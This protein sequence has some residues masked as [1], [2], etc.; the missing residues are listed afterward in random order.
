MAEGILKRGKRHLILKFDGHPGLIIQA[1][2]GCVAI[3]DQKTG[4]ET[5]ELA[6]EMKWR[7]KMCNREAKKIYLMAEADRKRLNDY[8]TELTRAVCSIADVFKECKEQ[9]D[10]T[11]PETIKM[12]RQSRKRSALM[13]G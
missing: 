3:T 13:L 7:A 4:E 11:D 5:L 1:I 12:I 9:G 8:Y 10:P 2:N 6:D